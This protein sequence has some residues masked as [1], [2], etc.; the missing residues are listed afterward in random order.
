MAAMA[1][2]TVTDGDAASRREALGARITAALDAH[3]NGF[4]DAALAAY[5]EVLPDVRGTGKLESTLRNN[6]AAIYMGQGNHAAA[7]THF[8]AAVAS[9]PDNPQ[10]HYNLAVLLTSKFGEHGKAIRHCG[11]A[12]K[13]DPAHT[14]AHHLMGNIL[15]NLGKDA[16]AQK[17]FVAAEA[18]AQEQGGGTSDEHD[19]SSVQSKWGR[20]PVRLARL[21]DVFTVDVADN[22]GAAARTL[23]MECISERPL[24]LRA[25]NVVTA[26]ECAHIMQRAGAKLERSHVMGGGAGATADAETTVTGDSTPAD[27]EPYRSSEN[28]WLHAD[29]VAAALQRRLAALTGLPLRLFRQRSEE[30]Q[31]VKYGPGGQFKVGDCTNSTHRNRQHHL[32]PPPPPL[33]H[34]H[35]PRCTRTARR[36][37]RGC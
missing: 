24:V 36:S 30:L 6:A 8:S 31:V 25:A 12:I 7:R 28:A 2:S 29:E 13:L 23:T 4:L 9:D 16:E 35:T 22:D 20:F 27:A 10:S 15:Q 34:T 18:L 33:P 19:T 1:S 3:K 14:K 26:D 5:E 11:T 37:T 32:S 17:Y 21:G